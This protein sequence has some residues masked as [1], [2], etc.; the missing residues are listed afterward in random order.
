MFGITMGWIQLYVSGKTDF[1]Q[2]LRRKLEHSSV[3]HMPGYIESY[4]GTD[5][6]DLYWLDGTVSLRDLKYKIGA[7][8]IWKHRLR[9]FT[10]LEDFLAAR[11]MPASADLTPR[12]QAMISE[13]RAAS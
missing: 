11:Q 6:A 5:P 10:T 9:F 2:D 12:E 3:S 4:P 8:L 7:K 1:R 13:M